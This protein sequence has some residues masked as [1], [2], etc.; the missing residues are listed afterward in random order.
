MLVNDIWQRLRLYFETITPPTEAQLRDMLSLLRKRRLIRVQWHEDPARFSES[1]VEI[2]PTLPRVIPFEN[3]AAWE[4][5]IVLYRQP[6][7]ETAKEVT[8]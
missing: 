7:A 3:A 6:M 4:Q 1:Q 8:P 2:L 5:Q